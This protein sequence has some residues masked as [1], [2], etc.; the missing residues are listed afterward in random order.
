[1]PAWS[2][3]NTLFMSLFMS[4]A[5]AR[6]RCLIRYLIFFPGSPCRSQLSSVFYSDRHQTQVLCICRIFVNPIQK[7]KRQ[8]SCFRIHVGSLNFVTWHHFSQW[9]C[10]AGS[11]IDGN[12]CMPWITAISAYRN[13]GNIVIPKLL[14]CR[15]AG[16]TA[17]SIYRNHGSVG[18]ISFWLYL[19]P[20]KI[21]ILYDMETINCR[22]REIGNGF[23]V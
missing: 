23:Y 6:T 12:I 1:M 5:A 2:A 10:P 15:Y 9:T 14:Q 13:H 17:M 18:M 20:A 22:N 3:G 7:M 19:R 16:I 21:R 11:G 8:N 4:P